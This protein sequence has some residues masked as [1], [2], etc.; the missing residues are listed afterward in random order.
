MFHYHIDLYKQTTLTVNIASH[1]SEVNFNFFLNFY[2]SFFLKI[3]ALYFSNI[4]EILGIFNI[5]DVNNK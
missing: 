3:K 5:N 1:D 2:F 4:G